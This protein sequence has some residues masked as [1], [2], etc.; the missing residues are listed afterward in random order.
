MA[1][2]SNRERYIKVIMTKLFVLARL[3]TKGELHFANEKEGKRLLVEIQ[4]ATSFL[5]K[6]M[7]MASKNYMY[8]QPGAIIPRNHSHRKQSN[9][10]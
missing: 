8:S 4:N 5:G 9:S 10:I 6:N 3:E 7:A 1:K 2:F